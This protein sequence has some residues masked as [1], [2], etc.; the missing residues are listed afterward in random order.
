MI[1]QRRLLRGDAGEPRGRLYIQAVPALTPPPDLHPGYSLTLRVVQK[2]LDAGKAG[3]FAC[4][5]EGRDLIVR[6]FKDITTEKMHEVWGLKE[7]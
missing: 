6:S 1:R 7:D 2:P 4:Q 3:V 5:D